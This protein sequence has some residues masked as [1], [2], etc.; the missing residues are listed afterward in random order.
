MK[1]GCV[2]LLPL[3]LKPKEASA[4]NAAFEVEAGPRCQNAGFPKDE[5]FLLPQID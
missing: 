1:T 3:V 5:T 4:W 2:G